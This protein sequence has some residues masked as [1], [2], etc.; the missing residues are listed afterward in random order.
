MDY[1]QTSF[2]LGTGSDQGSLGLTSFLFTD[3]SLTLVFT[4]YFEEIGK[5][6]D[7]LRETSIDSFSD[8]RSSGIQVFVDENFPNSILAA[9]FNFDSSFSLRELSGAD[10]DSHEYSSV[11]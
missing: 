9:L 1:V 7:K 10:D 3:D 11:V 8:M 6:S 2:D 4:A 5:E